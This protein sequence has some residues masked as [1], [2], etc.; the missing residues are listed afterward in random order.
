M[1]F[2]FLRPQ[3]EQNP[4]DVGYFEKVGRCPVNSGNRNVNESLPYLESANYWCLQLKQRRPIKPDLDLIGKKMF[5]SE[6]AKS[7]NRDLLP[8][9]SPAEADPE[10]GEIE[11]ESARPE[12]I[13]QRA[14]EEFRQP[15]LVEM[16]SA[17]QEYPKHQQQDAPRPPD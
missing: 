11:R 1:E 10:A 8:N 9:E 7:V 3:E 6:L 5:T 17:V 15:D 16:D 13:E 12:L 2:P 14:L 4:G